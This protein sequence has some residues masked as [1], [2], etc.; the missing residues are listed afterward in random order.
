MASKSGPPPIVYILVVLGVLGGGW[1]AASRLVDSKIEVPSLP[2]LVNRGGDE[3]LLLG[4]TFSGYSTFRND[5]FQ[6]ALEA[7]EIEL[8]YEDEFSQA[9]RAKRLNSGEAELIVT[10]LDRYLQQQPDG[11]IVGLI[12]RTVGADAVTLNT[13]QYPGLSSLNDLDALVDDARARGEQLSIAYAADTPSEYLAQVLDIRFENFNLS[14][15][16]AT[17]VAEASEAWQ[18]AQDPSQKIAVTVLWEPFV[19]QARQHGHTVVL[20]SQDA[21]NAILDVLVA[22]EHYMASNPDELSKLLEVYYRRIDANARD[23]SGLREQIQ[24]DGNLSATEATVVMDGI[25]FFTSVEANRWMAADTLPKRMQ[26]TAAVLA[27]S[28]Q[29]DDVPNDVTELYTSKFISEAVANTRALIALIETDNPELAQFLKG[30]VQSTTAVTTASTTRVQSAPD[31]GNLQVRGDVSFATGSAQLDAIGQQTIDRLAT[32]VQEF[33]AQTVAV[34]VIGHTSRTGSASLNQQLSQQ[35]AQ[36]VVDRLK[37]KGVVHTIVAEG[38]GF[39]EP[40]PSISPA[41]ARNQ[42]TEIRLV[43]LNANI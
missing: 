10:T 2:N 27:L 15:L 13:P 12:D 5:E 30:E 9:E 4:D 36:V 43:R 26:S 18:L 35:R 14:D 6:A 24:T 33:N 21:P 42:R 1:Y 38:K 8:R 17:E 16:R 7:A 40:L 29:L 32:E 37:S 34:R 11:K 25:D 39:S 23:R 19:T 20:S 41:D 28:G 31:I 22:S 3:V